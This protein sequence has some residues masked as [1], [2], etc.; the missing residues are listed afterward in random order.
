VLLWAS[1]RKSSCFVSVAHASACGVSC[2]QHFTH[3]GGIGREEKPR[4][5]Q[6]VN[7][8]PL[9]TNSLPLAPNQIQCFLFS[10]VNCRLTA[11]SD[12][13]DQRKGQAGLLHAFLNSG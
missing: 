13:L 8:V 4:I 3:D 9:H 5:P 12:P 6:P 10:R 11:R 1:S 2:I 7:T